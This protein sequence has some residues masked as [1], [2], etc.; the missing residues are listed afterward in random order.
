[1]K[2]LFTLFLLC[3]I[4]SLYAQEA[5]KFS[6]QIR[7]RIE[8]SNKDFSDKI[9]PNTYVEL[10]S[11]V[12]MLFSPL[13]T[14][15]AFVQVQDSRVMGTE[16][17]TMANTANL[18]LHQAYFELSDFLF[19]GFSVKAGRM[20]AAYANER[21][22]GAVDW[23]N[24]GRSFDGVTLIYRGKNYQADFF[25]FVER[26]RQQPGDR[27]DLFFLGNHWKLKF[28]ESFTLQPFIYYQKFMPADSLSRFTVGFHSSEVFGNFFGEVEGAY[29]FGDLKTGGKKTSISAF[30]AAV[31]VKYVIDAPTK[32]AIGAG[33]D[34]ISGDKDAADDKYGQF[35][36]LYATNHKFYGFMDYFTDLPAHTG[37]KGL[38]DI[39]FNA[40]FAP[41]DKWSFYLSAHIFNTMEDVTLLP[42]KT[43]K[44]L[45]TEIDATFTWKYNAN[46]TFNGG[47]GIFSPGELFKTTR[48][49][50]MSTWLYLMTIVNL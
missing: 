7:P 20:E 28:S 19:D 40:G 27:N 31:N 34:I 6:G 10:R 32:P 47:G 39:H 22:V 49:D 16:P 23:N 14:L 5:V 12:N 9:N 37:N 38:M 17:S 33:I 8:M 41:A 13:S 24:I 46:L 29:Q 36:T 30:L 25:T 15:K 1:M 43:S 42:G 3:G 45:G 11:R 18:D 2:K 48:G 21:L 50:K 26:E 44:A 4:L 35:N